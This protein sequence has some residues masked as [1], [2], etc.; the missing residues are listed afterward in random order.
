MLERKFKSIKTI[1]YVLLPV[2]IAYYLMFP[3]LARDYIYPI[4]E[5]ELY[6]SFMINFIETLKEGELPVWNEYVGCG[7]PA[8][9]FG[10]YPISQNT[11][12]YMYLGFNDFTFYFTKFIGLTI[13]LLSSIYAFKSLQFSY[14]FALIGAITYFSINFV[15]RFLM[16]DD[17]IGNILLVYPLMMVFMIKIIDKKEKRDVLIFSLM[18][19]FWLSGGHIIWV[20]MHIAMLSIIFWIS[21]YIFYE[22]E[23]FKLANLKKFVALYFV[24]FIVPFSAVLYQYYFIYDVI[25]TSNRL[26]EGLIVSPFEAVVWKQL[27]V[28]FQSSSYCWFGLFSALTYVILKFLP[29]DQ[30]PLRNKR[31]VV[32]PLAF[33]SS[34]AIL[35]YLTVTDSQF[36]STSYLIADYLPILNSK[37]F[38]IAL[39]SYFAIH[40]ILKRR[41]SVFSVSLNELFVFMIYVSLLSY[42]FYSPENIIGDV[43]GYDYDLFRELSVPFQILFTLSVLFSA[44]EYRESKVIKVVVLSLIALYFLR[45][46]LTIPLLRFTGIVWYA[47]RDGSI[48]SVFFAV[49]FMYGLRNMLSYLSQV[50]KNYEGPIVEFAKYGFLTC[51]LVLMVHDASYKFYKGTS[52]RYVFPNKKKLAK[53]PMEKWVIHGREEVAALKTKL[54][55]LNKE[56]KHFYR[57][58]SPENHYLCLTGNLQNHK[59]YEASIYETS[60]SKELWDLRDNIIFRE[61]PSKDLKDVM[62]YFLFTRHVH[63]GLN[64]THKEIRYGNS[65]F[66]FF[67]KD[68]IE[69]LQNQNIEFLWDLM[70]VKYLLIGP[71]FS[72]VLEGFTTHDQ[73]KL[74]EKYHKLNLNLYE[75][76]KDKSYSKFA[77]LP[78]NGKQSHDEMIKEL[79][80]TDINTLKTLYSKLVFL[81]SNPEDFT[82]TK[83]QSSRSARHYEILSKQDAILIDFES[84][85]HNWELRVNDKG[86]KL[87]KTFRMFK[88]I[89]LQPGLNQIEITYHLKYFKELFILSIFVIPIYLALLGRIY[90][91]EKNNK[92]IG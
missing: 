89:R 29:S 40:F 26:K 59:I 25:A 86:K 4:A 81:D 53:S 31:L 67:A 68:D 22:F 60:I 69:D 45:S 46:H 3:L 18:Y 33:Y 80:S 54:L 61:N 48:F 17:T 30:K 41:H 79:N 44:V 87:Q 77:V 15:T 34:S 91:A 28:S 58:F 24:L 23:A 62:P 13:L 75:I 63:A 76:L 16:P 10:H 21:V 83:N 19:I 90:Y 50:F 73:Y 8:L 38:R 85:N 5:Y 49:L 35:L 11:L 42:Y 72:L 92:K 82:L 84:W 55:A 78:L 32:T 39:L 7:H 36:A 47:T 66:M 14:L 52:H 88:G 65:S 56:T 64:L 70:Q 27:L 9:Q 43:H 2:G 37:V 12:I 57:M 74:L 71:E 6:K 51:L 20:Y 1:G